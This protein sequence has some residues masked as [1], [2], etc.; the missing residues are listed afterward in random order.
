V[1]RAVPAVGGAEAEKEHGKASQR[2]GMGDLRNTR[3]PIEGSV[4]GLHGG[5][6]RS[7]TA[8]PKER[9]RDRERERGEKGSRRGGRKVWKTSWKEVDKLKSN[10]DGTD[11][12]YGILSKKLKSIWSHTFHSIEISKKA[13]ER[14]YELI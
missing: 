9:D 4:I 13:D 3:A 11:S 8:M 6:L 12:I 14:F 1:E 7:A 2:T 10:G 5:E